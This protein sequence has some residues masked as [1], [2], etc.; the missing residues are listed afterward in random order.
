VGQGTIL[1]SGGEVE[2][3]DALGP[4]APGRYV[5]LLSHSGSRGVGGE[6]AR[7]YSSLA[8]KLHPELPPHLGQLAWLD[9]DSEEGQEYW[10]AMTL[11]GQYSAANHE[12]IHHRT[13][14]ALGASALFVVENHHNFA[15][16]ENIDS[17]VLVVHRKGA[18]PAAAGILGVIPGTM[19]HPAF[20]VEGL[21]LRAT[22]FSA[23]H[24][25][26]RRMGR[27][28]AMRAFSR[29][30][31]EDAVRSA[32]VILMGGGVDEIPLAYKDIHEV[33]ALQREVVRPR[34]RFVP[35]IVRMA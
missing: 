30:H 18:T 7:W 20:V 34:A 1:W 35:R 19:I 29:R 33:M 23:S 9:V 5:G 24:G 11:M 22:L 13:I 12:L 21:G 14:Q 27:K 26:G 31:L 10:A 16:M 28:E 32:G 2:I 25:A 3:W 4:L 15:W 6:V 17:E 8:R